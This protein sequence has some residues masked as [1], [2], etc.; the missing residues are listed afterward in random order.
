[1]EDGKKEQTESVKEKVLKSFYFNVL[2]TFGEFEL[3]DFKENSY[4]GGGLFIGST[5]ILSVI[6]FNMIVAQM[7][8][9]Y[10]KMLSTIIESDTKE[11]NK[12][13]VTYESTLFI[14]R[15]KFCDWFCTLFRDKEME[16]VPGYLYWVTYSSDLRE[17]Q[18]SQVQYVKDYVED[19]FS[20]M[21]SKI[22]SLNTK[23]KK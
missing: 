5:F 22:E 2:Y 17:D 7:T 14:S 18:V 23:N 10:E 4:S 1:M 16:D 13:I 15:A 9:V 12:L 8:D 21:N 6:L 19:L 11:L 20:V 3:S